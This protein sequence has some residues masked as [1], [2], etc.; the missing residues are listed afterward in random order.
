M[1]KLCVIFF[2]C[3][4]EQIKTQLISSNKFSNIYNIKFIPIY[5]YLKDGKKYSQDESLT[6]N[7]NKLIQNCDLII[8]QYIKNPRKNIHH[9]YIKSLVKTDCI[10][11]RIPHYTFS[12]YTYHHDIINDAF[13]D[14]KKSKLELETYIN[15]LFINDKD[16]ILIHLKN[17]LEH[18]KNLDLISDIK[19]YD[20]IKNNYDKKFLFYSRSYPTYILFHYMAEEILRILNIYDE[21]QPQYTLY[22]IHTLEP[23]YPNVKK[24]LDLQFNQKS[25]N[26][27]CNLIEYLICCKINN[28]NKLLLQERKNEGIQHCRPIKEIIYCGKYR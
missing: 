5:D 13:I 7:D 4:G 20:F 6:N 26:F 24:Y 12:G 17:E 28:T 1:K 11:I 9:E 14:I 15:N 19:C 3:H 27:K 22:A 16:K 25:F 18:I 21:I 10:I 8:L 2:N 23:I